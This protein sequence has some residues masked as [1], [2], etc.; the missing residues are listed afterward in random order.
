[1]TGR[2]RK[3]ESETV[4]SG[5]E[6][7]VNA[8]PGV[9][10]GRIWSGLFFDQAYSRG[11]EGFM[12]SVMSR[13]SSATGVP[14]SETRTRASRA[15][16]N[17]SRAPSSTTRSGGMPKKSVAELAFQDMNANNRLRHR[18]IGAGPPGSSRARPR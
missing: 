17:S 2:P 9:P 15:R 7:S 4:W 8:G 11:V 12:V 16:Q 1:M 10:A 13:V 14:W 3:S 6:C 5:V 18:I